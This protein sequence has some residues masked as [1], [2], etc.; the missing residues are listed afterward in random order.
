ML[1][2]QCPFL[3]HRTRWAP[4]PTKNPKV[5]ISST[6]RDLPRAPQRG[7]GRLSAPRMFPVMMEHLPASDAEA[8]GVSLALVDEADI[9][10]GIFAHRYRLCAQGHAISVTEMEYNP[11][12][13]ASIPRLIFVMDDEHPIRPKMWRGK[14]G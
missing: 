10:V 1:I 12:S 6:A 13:N 5:M 3:C 4:M 9:Y 2:S 7:D 14:R 8:I 11:R